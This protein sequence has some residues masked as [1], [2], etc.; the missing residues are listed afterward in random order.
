MIVKE[1]F[2]AS[3]NNVP[4]L[5]E[6][7][8]TTNG[9]KT[10][11]HEYPNKKF[12]YV[13][14]MG[15]H[16]RTFDIKAIITGSGVEYYLLREAFIFALQKKGIGML[17]HPFYGAV[18]V[19]VAKPY[20]ISEDMSRVGECVFSIHFEEANENVYPQLSGGTTASIAAYLQDIAPYLAAA[21]VAE[22]TTAFQKNIP[23][24]GNKMAEFST[25]LDTVILPFNTADDS[26]NDF[27]SNNANFY[28][29]RYSLISTKTDLG[30][31]V[32]SLLSDFD[33]LA[34]TSE[35][36]YSLNSKVYYFGRD[37]INILTAPTVT[38]LIVERIN[39][40]LTFNSVVNAFILLNLYSNATLI[41]YVDDQQLASISSDLEEKHQ[42]LMNNNNL[43]KNIIDMLETARSETRKFFNDLSVNIS[44]VISVQT[45]TTPLS[46]LLYD[47]YENFDNENEIVSLNGILDATTI[48]GTIK[49]LTTQ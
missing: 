22:I 17:M 28:N 47:Y 30:T 23:D 48:G 14:D 45:N 38:P 34:L 49:V 41:T 19:V 43:P 40:R 36:G 18:S 35:Y 27:R 21:A 15:E 4:F 10:V 1:L 25:S 8:D 2:P 29:T 3:F 26:L 42:Y 20:T 24:M 39:N 37:D 33:F 11:T 46:V 31:S 13:E 12:R 5:M 6:A 9:R 16:L 44:K 32:Q 7:S